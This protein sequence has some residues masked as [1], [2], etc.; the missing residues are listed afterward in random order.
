ML[1]LCRIVEMACDTSIVHLNNAVGKFI[2]TAVVS[3]DNYA[4]VRMNCTSTE[5]FESFVS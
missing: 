3:Y 5:Q 2:N 4:A 1:E